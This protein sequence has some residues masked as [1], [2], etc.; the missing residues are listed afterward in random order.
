MLTPFHKLIAWFLSF[1]MALGIN[2]SGGEKY[3]THTIRYGEKDCNIMDVFVPLSAY[4]REYNGIILNVHG[5]SWTG[6]CKEEKSSYIRRLAGAGYIVATMNYSVYKGS[7][8]VNGFVMLDDITSA[9]NRIVSFSDEKNLNI[10]K[11]C[12]SGYSAGAHLCSWY[13]YSRPEESPIEIVMA[14]FRVAPVD[15]HKD[16]WGSAGLGLASMLAGVKITDE[17][18]ADGKSEEI[19]NSVSPVSYITPDSVPT[20]YAYGGMD[21]VVPAGN[22]KSLTK[23]LNAAGVD[24]KCIIYPHS[25]HMLEFDS[26]SENE[27]FSAVCDYLSVYFGY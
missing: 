12:M 5:G 6:G 8:D 22:E 21:T 17:M 26:K 7:D 10:T 18:K 20:V 11:V 4:E 23:A 16:V 27:Y 15:F 13:S 2:L 19:I 25:N 1:F 14:A 24:S 9:L 3:E